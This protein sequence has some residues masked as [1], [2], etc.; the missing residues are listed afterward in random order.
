MQPK[1][2]KEPLGETGSFTLGMPSASE[3]VAKTRANKEAKAR[4]SIMTISTSLAGLP[5]SDLV[6]RE[7]KR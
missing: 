4:L 2:L 5:H 7:K 1:P 6:E 3:L